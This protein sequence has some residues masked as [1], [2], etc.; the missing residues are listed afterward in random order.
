MNNARQIDIVHATNSHTANIGMSAFCTTAGEWDCSVVQT[1]PN[2]D[3]GQV[4]AKPG[5]PY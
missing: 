5:N 3:A 2:P 4:F 1:P